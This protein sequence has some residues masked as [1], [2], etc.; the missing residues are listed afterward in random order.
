MAGIRQHTDVLKQLYEYNDFP[1]D[2]LIK[3]QR[4][5]LGFTAEFNSRVNASY[6]SEEVAGELIRIRKSKDH[7]GGLPHLGRSCSGPRY[8]APTSSN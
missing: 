8:L 1:S 6:S 5:L 2:P 3:N 4:A 7:T